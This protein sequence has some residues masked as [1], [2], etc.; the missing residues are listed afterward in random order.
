M[1]RAIA[2]GLGGV[3]V[4]CSSPKRVVQRPASWASAWAGEQRRK[5][6]AAFGVSFFLV[7]FSLHEQREVTCRGVSHPQVVVN[8]ARRALYIIIKE[9]AM[10]AIRMT[11]TGGPDVLEARDVPMPELPTPHHVRVRGCTPPA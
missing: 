4:P 11:R 1:A 7:T 6:S 3:A 10:F 5:G 9:I 2:A 8:R